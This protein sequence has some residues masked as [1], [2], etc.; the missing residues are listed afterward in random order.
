MSVVV[1]NTVTDIA[2]FLDIVMH[3]PFPVVAFP[4][5]PDTTGR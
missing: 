1:R 5:D 4:V 2:R 3:V